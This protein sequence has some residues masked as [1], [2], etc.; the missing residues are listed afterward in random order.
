[1]LWLLVRPG[2]RC[3]APT[4]LLPSLHGHQSNALADFSYAIALAGHCQAGQ[5]ALHVPTLAQPAR[6]RRRFER[7]FRPTSIAASSR[8]T[9]SG[10][11]GVGS[12]D[13]PD[14]PLDP[15]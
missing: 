2:R 9:R 4:D 12:V 13:G 10:P 5:V 3:V 15:C 11:R 8:A 14:R 6:A 7:L 1:M